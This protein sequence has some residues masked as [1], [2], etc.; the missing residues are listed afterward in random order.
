[1]RGEVVRVEHKDRVARLIR[2][3]GELPEA[4][5][6]VRPPGDED[7]LERAQQVGLFGEGDV[8]FAALDRLAVDGQRFVAEVGPVLERLEVDAGLLGRGQGFVHETVRLEV[9]ADQQVERAPGRVRRP[10]V[11]GLVAGVVELAD[12]QAAVDPEDLELAR[13]LRMLFVAGQVERGVGGAAESKPRPEAVREERT[14]LLVARR[15]GGFVRNLAVE[16]GGEGGL[17]WSA[18]S[19]W[20]RG[21]RW[22]WGVFAGESRRSF[23]KTTSGPSISPSPRAMKSET[24]LSSFLCWRT[25]LP[26][27]SARPYISATGWPS[28][29]PRSS[30]GAFF[31]FPL[32]N[33]PKPPKPAPSNSPPPSSGWPHSQPNWNPTPVSPC[34]MIALVAFSVQHSA[35]SLRFPDR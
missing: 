6:E 29:A 7:E 24:D 14:E 19:R 12:A 9:A 18:L 13:L 23:T 25:T 15:R 32:R 22:S 33:R 27:T 3:R 35:F 34:G 26:P 31:F 1:M 8:A 17:F 30:S 11:R 21:W 4:L 2:E 16:P 28:A 10:G 20:G 5:E